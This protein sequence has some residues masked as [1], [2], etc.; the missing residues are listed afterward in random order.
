MDRNSPPDYVQDTATNLGEMCSFLA[1]LSGSQ[2]AGTRR[3][4]RPVITPRFVPT[5]TP[6]LLEGV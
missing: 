4:V 3:L 1:A 2:P 5:C 6:E